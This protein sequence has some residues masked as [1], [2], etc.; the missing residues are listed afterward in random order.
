[1]NLTVGLPA[2]RFVSVGGWLLCTFEILHRRPWPTQDAG[3]CSNVC[4]IASS[5]RALSPYPIFIAPGF[6]LFSKVGRIR[7][8]GF[9][10]INLRILK[11]QK[12]N[13]GVRVGADRGDD[14]VGGKLR[15]EQ[16][17]GSLTPQSV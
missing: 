17:L 10:W 3:S 11:E 4:G 9:S 13:Q 7:S 5:R 2:S 15:G 16:L 1:V 12:S 8:A 6:I 14:R